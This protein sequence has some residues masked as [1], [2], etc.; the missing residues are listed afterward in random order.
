MTHI[1][2]HITR[3]KA[4]TPSRFQVKERRRIPIHSEEAYGKLMAM[5]V[6]ADEKARRGSSR[7]HPNA[8][9]IYF[10]G[11]KTIIA[12]VRDLFSVGVVLT[13]P[14]VESA[15][16]ISQEQAS[17]ALS[18]LKD[19][20]ILTSRRGEGRSYSWQLSENAS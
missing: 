2:G 9:P 4:P 16:E 10:R 5:Q 20:G 8:V 3:A 15:L 19:R 1:S 6:K 18:A 7:E 13:R 12:R 14:E 17:T 11:G